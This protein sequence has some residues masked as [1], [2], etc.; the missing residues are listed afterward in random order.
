MFGLRLLTAV[1][2]LSSAPGTTAQSGALYSC[3]DTQTAR[4]VEIGMTIC[5]AA[6][7]EALAARLEDDNLQRRSGALITDVSAGSLA[8]IAGLAPGDVIYRVGGVDVEDEV[9]T[10]TQ[11]DQIGDDAD[12]VVN[13]LRGGR[14]YRVKLRQR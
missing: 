9:E 12:T 14:P 3:V 6:P 7:T 10:S 11:L 13:F 2:I 5:N 4:P 1:A 8:Q